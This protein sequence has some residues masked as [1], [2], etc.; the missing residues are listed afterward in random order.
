MSIITELLSCRLVVILL[1]KKHNI[2]VDISTLENRTTLSNCQLN[3][4]QQVYKIKLCNEPMFVDT[5][6][7]LPESTI[8]KQFYF[9]SNLVL[10][11]E[12]DDQS[13][14]KYTHSFVCISQ[15]DKSNCLN[16][17]RN[18]LVGN[19]NKVFNLQGKSLISSQFPIDIQI[20][21][22]PFDDYKQA[23]E[24]NSVKISLF[25]KLD[26]NSFD[27]NYEV[28][29]ET[30]DLN[31][32][33]EISLPKALS[34]NSFYFDNKSDFYDKT[35]AQC[36]GGQDKKRIDRVENG[37][38]INSMESCLMALAQIFDYFNFGRFYITKVVRVNYSGRCS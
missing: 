14:D 28:P 11:G 10:K 2:D 22:I 36:G 8:D 7:Y 6:V 20:G 26:S 34:N 29:Q 33:L 18:L 31:N 25:E 3:K 17:H 23:L 1:V 32:K 38:L 37:V 30:V 12:T 13:Q 35:T 5:T 24:I 16:L 27:I 9:E 15:T 19:K 21:S 4:T